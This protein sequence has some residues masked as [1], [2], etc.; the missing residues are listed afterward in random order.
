MNIN[1][2]TRRATRLA[3]FAIAGLA[4]AACSSAQDNTHQSPVTFRGGQGASITL[5]DTTP[6]PTVYALT[7]E[8][9]QSQS[10][11]TWQ[12]EAGPVYSFGNGRIVISGR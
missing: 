2:K 9:Q 7:G 11:K 4:S 8:N 6:V 10:E 5:P 1:P 3:I 12:H